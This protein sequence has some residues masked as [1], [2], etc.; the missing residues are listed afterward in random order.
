M[1]HDK[2]CLVLRS[3]NG[4]PHISVLVSNDSL[5]LVLD[6]IL[7]AAWDDIL[8]LARD[9]QALVH[10]MALALGLR[11]R[12][13]ACEEHVQGDVAHDEDDAHDALDASYVHTFA[14]NAYA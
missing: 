9:N 6:D 13:L 3:T 4:V 7:A 1:V 10:D 12:A 8:V 5:V 2:E 14:C 11:I